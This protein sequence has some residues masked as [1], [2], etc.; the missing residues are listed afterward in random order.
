MAEPATLGK[1]GAKGIFLVVVKV[2]LTCGDKVL[3]AIFADC[4]MQRTLFRQI[5]RLFLL[6]PI[7]QGGAIRPHLIQS[8]EFKVQSSNNAR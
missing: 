6:V 5:V 8:T 1:D 2:S 7:Y 3:P 4:R